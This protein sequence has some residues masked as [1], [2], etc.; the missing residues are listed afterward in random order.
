MFRAH[1]LLFGGALLV[2]LAG[3]NAGPHLNWEPWP[4]DMNINLNGPPKATTRAQNN[5]VEPMGKEPNGNGGKHDNGEEIP[6]DKKKSVTLFEWAIGKHAPDNGEDIL[7]TIVT[8]RPD[9]TEASSTVGRGRIQLEAGYTFIRDAAGD[10][11]LNAHSYPEMLWRIGMFADWFEL[12]IGQ[13]FL[14]E[15]AT[16]NGIRTTDSGAEDLYLGVK[17]WLTE[18]K[19][20]LP[21]T[22][23]ILQ[24]TVPTGAAAFTSNEVQP[25]ISFLYGWDIIPDFL[26]LGGS[27][28]ANRTLGALDSEFPVATPTEL[29]TPGQGQ[30]SFLELAQSLTVNYELTRKLGAYT[31]WFALFPHSAR[32]ADVGPEYYVDGGFTYKVTNNFQLDIRAGLGLNAHADNYFA[33]SGFSVRF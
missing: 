9:F 14:S 24:M 4:A 19:G 31:E 11:R 1:L 16:D 5:D 21:E 13:N 7:E 18:Q 2:A 20:W 33:G 26:S 6:P 3:C 15:V 8:D 29:P 12:R 32:S 27:T 28:L 10:S 22:A 30:H 17:L 25:G 23:L